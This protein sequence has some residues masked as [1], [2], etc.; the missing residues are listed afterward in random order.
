MIMDISFMF[1]ESDAC[2]VKLTITTLA[3]LSMVRSV[4]GSHYKSVSEPSH[5]MLSGLFENILD[6]HLCMNNR[7]AI[8][9]EIK[10]VFDKDK[11]KEDKFEFEETNSSYLPIIAHLFTVELILKPPITYFNDLWKR[12]YRRSDAA[13]HPK[14]TPNLDHKMIPMKK[15]LPVDDRGKIKDEDYIKLFKN[16]LG[17]FPL[18]YSTLSSREYIKTDGNYQIKMSMDKTLYQHLSDALTQNDLGYLGSN[19]GWVSLKLEII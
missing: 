15:L 3:P 9:K 2:L 11:K 8:R 5:M 4:P 18:Y 10:K 17:K 6:L 14:G 1:K 12:A 19:D 16:N 7:M 13:V